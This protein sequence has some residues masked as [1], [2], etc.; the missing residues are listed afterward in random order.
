MR[1]QNVTINVRAHT[2][3]E[4]YVEQ[5]DRA[6]DKYSARWVYSSHTGVSTRHVPGSL[7]AGDVGGEATVSSGGGERGFSD[8]SVVA[9][10]NLS[11]YRELGRVLV[12]RAGLG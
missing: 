6:R 1:A 7:F 12:H 4:V 11:R 8:E 10:R 9:T 3:R 2:V 5:K